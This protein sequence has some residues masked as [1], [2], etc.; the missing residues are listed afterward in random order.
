MY[1]R[2]FSFSEC[3]ISCD[4]EF[5]QDEKEAISRWHSFDH[6]FAIF[7]IATDKVHYSVWC[8][9]GRKGMRK[10]GDVTGIRIEVSGKQQKSFARELNLYACLYLY[11]LHTVYD[12]HK[13]QTSAFIIRC[14]TA[15]RED[16]CS[17]RK[18]PYVT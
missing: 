2:Y 15:T 8:E 17:R 9:G 16:T 4:I 7:M 12:F 5:D 6:S 11:T 13:S 18:T 14:D 1:S 10:G 3:R